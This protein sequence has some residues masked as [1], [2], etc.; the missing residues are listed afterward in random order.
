MSDV[1]E[2]P[3]PLRMQPVDVVAERDRYREALE[4]IASNDL[5]KILYA[6][7]RYYRYQ[8][9]ILFARSVLENQ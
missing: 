6:D 4:R 1:N 2:N 8:P 7:E 5:P 9:A 3:T